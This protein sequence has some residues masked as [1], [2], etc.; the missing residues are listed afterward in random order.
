MNPL[1]EQTPEM[2]RLVREYRSIGT[3]L[4]NVIQGDWKEWD[5][6]FSEDM[7]TD[8]LPADAL[9]QVTDGK[10]AI[11]QDNKT[12][13]QWDEGDVFFSGDYYI[14]LAAELRPHIVVEDRVVVRFILMNQV[15]PQLAAQ[16][17]L[18]Q[19]FQKVHRQL[20]QQ[21]VCRLVPDDQRPTPGFRR[22]NDGEVIIRE[23]DPAEYVYT[24]MDGAADVYVNGV[25]VGAI[26]QEEIFGAMAVLCGQPRTAT[27]KARGACNVLMV[28]PQEFTTLLNT[29]PNMFINLLR[30][31]AKTI[32]N[33]NERVVSLEAR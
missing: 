9:V 14:P 11:L 12:L 16:Q 27:V 2:L 4:S 19:R 25:K 15:W 22:Y 21:L 33:L 7:I 1:V 24:I 23:G 13:Y 20:M 30:D 18:W 3:D 6:D 5:C 32:T 17:N 31:L 26:A 28:P 29:H 10:L 8:G